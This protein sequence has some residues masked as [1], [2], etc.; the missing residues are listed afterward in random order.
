MR[1][2]LVS[3]AAVILV[4]TTVKQTMKNAKDDNKAEDLVDLTL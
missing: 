4:S 2:G 1:E 3:I